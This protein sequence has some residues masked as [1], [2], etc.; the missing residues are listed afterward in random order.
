MDQKRKSMYISKNT[1][2]ILSKKQK[3]ASSIEARRQD[4]QKQFSKL[5]TS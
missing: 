5:P 3:V 2:R 1:K 4:F